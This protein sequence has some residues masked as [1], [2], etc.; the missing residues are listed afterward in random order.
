MAG[1][2]VEDVS[3]VL[4]H[5]YSTALDLARAAGRR[6]DEGSLESSTLR[7]LTLA[8]D[9]ALSLDVARAE[10]HY[11]KA[12]ELAGPGHEL[13]PEVLARWAEA[14]RQAG[15]S[16]EA[17]TALEKAIQEFLRR[18]ERLAA[19]RTMGTLSSVLVIIGSSRHE[20]VA[21]TAV[22]LLESEPPGPDLVAAYARMAGVKLVQG[23]PRATVAWAERA[24]ALAHGLGVEVPAR[25]LGFRGYAR[26]SLGDREGLED[27]RMAL[28]L[29]TERG[30]GRDAA[31]LYNNLAVAVWPID[32][33][34][35]VLS[36]LREGIEFSEHRGITEL[37]VGMAAAALDQL[38]EAGEWDEALR[39]AESIA[40]Q[41]EETGDMAALLQARWSQTRLLASRGDGVRA[42]ELAEWLVPAAR[43]SGGA[44][45]LIAG[46][47]GA[48]LAHLAVG[49]SDLAAK[50]VSEVDAGPH[51]REGPT[52]PAFLCEM[53]RVACAAGDVALAARLIGGVEA[54][55]PYHEHALCAAE[56]ILLEARGAHD[57]AAS[58]HREAAG[59]WRE[60]GV[61]PE[62]GFALFGLGRCLLAGG[63]AGEATDPLR[64]AAET[65]AR[66]GAQPTLVEV[67]ALLEKA[68]SLAS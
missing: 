48:A 63:R 16:P 32:G 25:A 62:R 1:E 33:P 28:A 4:A 67:N 37:A 26:C 60:F 54:L 5:H 24:V 6:E 27:M 38:I 13:R 50:L 8:G 68:T 44:E 35:G 22:D 47:T 46:L 51:S 14:A 23:D 9:R 43:E 30:E 21:A 64:Q 17:A 34:K 7:F 3:E 12:L 31:V 20:E 11:A 66:L 36:V 53:V 41:A 10:Q 42:A 52:Y 65:F 19:G 56:A 55:F 45:D 29:A 40:L 57:A 59:R 61:L 18:G 2:R 58:R 49:R 15:R 39:S